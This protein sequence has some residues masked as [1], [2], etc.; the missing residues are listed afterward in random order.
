MIELA[1][2]I[3]ER[4]FNPPIPAIVFG[5]IGG[6]ANAFVIGHFWLQGRV[7][8]LKERMVE[9]GF[10][11]TEVERVM[12]AAPPRRVSGELARA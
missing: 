5:S 1:S 4:F 2:T 11:A 6:V 10:S 3:A 8:R 7:V 9:Q 12:R